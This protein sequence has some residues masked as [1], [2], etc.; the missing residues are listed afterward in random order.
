MRRV[1]PAALL[2]AV[3]IAAI[4]GLSAYV[5]TR[6]S[7]ATTLTLK[8]E[9]IVSPSDTTA[10]KVIRGAGAQ[11]G[12]ATATF[13]LTVENSADDPVPNVLVRF[14]ATGA[15][16]SALTGLTDNQG[17]VTVTV[18]GQSSAPGSTA[19]VLVE[20]LVVTSSTTSWES[21]TA[22]IKIGGAAAACELAL[23]TAADGTLA[24]ALTLTDGGDN[25]VPDLTPVSFDAVWQGPWQT[26]WL[27]SSS[28]VLGQHAA[29]TAEGVATATLVPP[30][31][32][33]TVIAAVGD[34]VCTSA[35][36]D[37]APAPSTAATPTAT[38]TPAPAPTPTPTPTPTP[39]Q[40]PTPAPTP[41]P[42]ATPTPQTAPSAAPFAPLAPDAIPPAGRPVMLVYSG[43]AA[44]DVTVLVEG[45]P[46][47]VMSAARYD[48]FLGRFDVFVPD[49][50][51]RVNSLQQI[52]PGDILI[53][54]RRG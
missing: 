22:T 47:A 23:T 13:R 30:A 24:A 18:D 16:L 11:L 45:L 42:T 35:I 9:F 54:T 27:T 40:T 43:T 49:A 6:A 34:V 21:T 26:L 48:R 53:V 14:T 4:V 29:T 46:F 15:T 1:A 2:L 7:A 31:A 41:A 5:A 17:R 44:L 39:A 20:V 38:P 12:A 36:V 25:S 32:S 50:P 37:G 33:G 3:T 10:L 28:L 52:R 51:A 19:T 8:T